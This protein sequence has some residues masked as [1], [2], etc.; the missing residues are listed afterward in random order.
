MPIGT[1]EFRTIHSRVAW[2]FSPVDRSITVSAPQRVA[3]CIFCTSSSIDERTAELPML[4]LTFTK[5]LRPMIIGSLSG[6]LTFDRQN[7]AAA[8]DFRPHE[9][10]VHVLPRGDEAHLRRDRALPGVVQLRDWA[11][12]AD[13]P[14][15]PQ[16]L[17]IRC[18]AAG[19]FSGGSLVAIAAGANPRP[20]ERR[21]T[22]ANLVVLRP[23]G[24]VNIERVARRSG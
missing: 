12:P 9:L 11:A 8:S 3:H 20:A 15:P 22:L 16:L 4:A 2:M 10:G 7:G 13:N 5:K 24:V 14:G 23:A 18:S 17:G 19:S 21:Q 1:G 6:W